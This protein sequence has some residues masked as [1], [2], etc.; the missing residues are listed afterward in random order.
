MRI[1]IAEANEQEKQFFSK[2]FSNAYITSKLLNDL[3]KNVLS[4]AE[5]VSIFIYSKIDE[6]LLKNMP[7]LKY[8]V[9]RSAGYNHIDLEACKKRGIKVYNVPD[10]GDETVAEFALMLM[11][12][13]L[14]KLKNIMTSMWFSPKIDYVALRG[15]DLHGKTVGIIGTGRIGKK[16]IKLL[17]GFEVKILAYDLYPD[18]ELEKKYEVNYVGLDELFK[19]SDIISLHVPLTPQ[20]KHLINKKAIKKM[21]KGVVIINTARGELIDSEALLEGIKEGRIGGAALDVVESEKMIID[22]GDLQREGSYKNALINHILLKHPNVIITPHIAYDTKEA[23]ERIIKRS[24]EH[25]SSL[26][27]HKPIKKEYR[28]A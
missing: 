21:K 27:S 13:V 1:V 20:T 26:L 12:A 24:Y 17:Y 4:K 6:D 5:I 7:N 8:V 9:T 2:R 23:V 11:L 18:E 15:N 19:A 25:I 10:Y 14:R 22:E 3:P 16:L 28:I